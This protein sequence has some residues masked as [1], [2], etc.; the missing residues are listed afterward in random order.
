MKPKALLLTLGLLPICSAHAQPVAPAATETKPE[1]NNDQ[2]V[3]LEAVSVTGSNIKRMD[4]EKVLPVSVFSAAQIQTRDSTTPSDLL[5]AIPEITNIPQ[6]ETGLGAVGGRGGNANVALRGLESAN[7][8][9]LLNGRRLPFFPFNTSSVN[10]NSLPTFG[11]AQV[12]VLRDGASAIYGSDAVAGVINYV[13]DK[14]PKGTQ[15]SV[16]Y[17]VTEHGGGMDI[18]GDFGTGVSF[19]D[20]KGTLLINAGAYYRDKIFLGERDI[21][22]STDHTA[23]ARP[24]FDAS[25]SYQGQSATAANVYAQFYLGTSTTTT[26]PSRYFYPTSGVAGDTP[27][28]QTTAIPKSLWFNANPYIVGQPMAE[29]YTLYNRLDYDLTKSL[30]AFVEVEGYLANSLTGRAPIT[31]SVGDSRHPQ[32]AGQSTGVYLSIGNPY[33][34]YGSRFYDVNGAPNSDGTARLTGTP[35]EVTLTNILM[36]DGGPDKIR[37]NESSYRVVSGLSGTFGTSSWTWESAVNIGGVRAADLSVNAIR[38]SKLYEAGQRTDATAWNPFGYTFKVVSGAVVAD[39][40]YVNPDSVKKTYTMSANRF[41]HSKLAS[42]DARFGGNVVDLWAGPVAFSTGLEW[43]YEFKEDH[44]DP[45]VSFN[46]PGTGLD[47]ADNDILVTSPKADYAAS[48]TIASAFAETV[49]PLIATK[50]DFKYTNTLEM[51]ASVRYERYSDFGNTTKPKFGLNWRP[52]PA[53]MIRASLNK[54][55]RAPDLASLYQPAAF[56][57]ASPPGVRD[58]AR[59]NIKVAALGTRDDQFLTRTYSLPTP[60]LQAEQSE[61]RSVGVVFDVPKIKGLSLTVDYWEIRQKSLIVTQT[62]SAG[63]DESKLRAFTQAQLATGKPIMSIDVGFHETPDGPNTYQGDPFLLRNAVTQADRDLFAQIYASGKIPNDQLI[64]PLGTPVG[65]ISKLVNS[66]GNNFTN[67][68][69]YSVGYNLP[70]MSIG[71]FRF[72]TEWS[73]FLNKYTRL[74]PSIGKNDD[75]ISMQVSRWKSNTTLQWRKGGWDASINGTFITQVRTGASATLAQYTSSGMPDY[76]K[77]VTVVSATGT[78]VISYFERGEDKWQFNT[79]LSYRFGPQAN[80]WVRRT[81]VRFGINNILDEDPPL[82]NT[83]GAGYN[84]NIGQSLWVGRA[85]SFAVSRDF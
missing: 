47:P 71:Q 30:H 61:G 26:A 37:A 82:Q 2:V 70:R 49:V 45:Y 25:G 19:A 21:S 69:D 22:K 85:Y 10:V 75:L 46:P 29:R 36:T 16:R 55:F 13:T 78:P 48:R 44:K 42:W 11:I 15:M 77:P 32:S 50:N 54:G 76:I 62:V 33:N 20:G 60:D 24:P 68:F 65:S 67:G 57:V 31:L 80:P 18:K 72:S 38:Q 35:Q 39:Q 4:Q 7:T 17:G 83:T 63:L 12:E 52:I 79:G 74:T 28:L 27:A 64:A 3:Q 53:V 51:N 41:G 43:R 84:G 81:T 58:T 23:M 9:V 6:N 40:K 5:L 1:E 34:P 66:I 8:L 14:K 59:D 73:Q 56:S